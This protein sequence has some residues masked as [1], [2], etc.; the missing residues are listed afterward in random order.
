MI[1]PMFITFTGIDE[2]TSLYQLHE[3]SRKY[4]VE[5][6]ILCSK[7]RGSNRYPSTEAIE[8]MLENRKFR[9]ALHLCG[10]YARYV[11]KYSDVP[12]YFPGMSRCR[13][14]VNHV[15]PDVAVLDTVEH[16][17]CHVIAQCRGETF[18][19]DGKFT[20]LFDKSGGTGKTPT[21]WPPHPGTSKLH[22][23][24]G[25]IGPD[26]VLPTLEAINCS[27]PY[28][29]DMESSLRDANDRFDTDRCW[30][31]CQLVYGDDYKM[32]RPNSK[33]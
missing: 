20:W 16:L 14:Q 3:L 11:M 9:V 32:D 7:N 33:W 25:G 22:G 29:I 18:P 19:E 8:Y 12:P 21:H 27:H 4:P 5:F 10:D 2:Y 17:H 31:V 26:N 15:N 28:W 23:Y 24:A 6:G 13:V 1:K 30:E